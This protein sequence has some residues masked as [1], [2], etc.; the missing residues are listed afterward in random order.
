MN[1]KHSFWN[2]LFA[3]LLLAVMLV[4]QT[5]TAFAV[6]DSP[7]P[8]EPSTVQAQDSDTGTEEAGEGI[9]IPLKMK[10]RQRGQKRPCRRFPAW[11]NCFRQSNG[12]KPG[13]LLELDVKSSARME[14]FL[15]THTSGLHFGE[16]PLK[17]I[18]API[19]RMEPEM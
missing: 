5:T 8:T 1:T 17:A 19:P 11:K 15:V 7:E 3:A 12:Q 9:L 18:S 4:T 13:P 14:R 16:R 6:E 10:D 2:R